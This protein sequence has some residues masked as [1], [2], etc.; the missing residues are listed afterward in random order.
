MH[1]LSCIR[2]SGADYS[3]R[4][5][6]LA[7]HIILNDREASSF[8]AAGNTPAGVM[9]GEQWPAHDGYCG[10][11]EEEFFLAP[12]DPE[13]TWKFWRYYAA[14]PECR[15][16]LC[17][18]T[19]LRGAVFVY[20]KGLE[21]QTKEE[22][23]GVLCLFAESQ[24][25][26]ANHGWGITFTTSVEPNDE[27]SE[28][29]WIGVPEKSPLLA[30]L[31]NATDREWVTLDSPPVLRPL[32]QPTPAGVARSP[33]K[34]APAPRRPSDSP[35]VPTVGGLG[36]RGVTPPPIGAKSE[37]AKT[38]SFYERVENWQI[39]AVAVLLLAVVAVYVLASSLFAPPVV[40]FE[41]HLLKTIYSGRPYDVRPLTVHPNSD[42]AYAKKGTDDWSLD[43]PVNAERYA[44]RLETRGWFG[45]KL[46]P[47][48][49]VL[50]IEKQRPIIRFA[51]NLEFAQD[52]EG[53]K[54][55]PQI[56]PPEAAS[57]VQ[58]LFKIRGMTNWTNSP[59]RTVGV[60]EVQVST[61]ET[62]NYYPVTAQT[63]FKIT[64]PIVE[65]LALVEPADQQQGGGASS[66]ALAGAD[67]STEKNRFVL[68]PESMSNQLLSQINNLSAGKPAGMEF[69]EIG[70]Q[71]ASAPNP[72]LKKTISWNLTPSGVPSDKPA[73]YRGRPLNY[74]L[75]YDDGT[76][77]QIFE[78]IGGAG[79]AI[80][81][82]FNTGPFYLER[83]GAV[84]HQVRLAPQEF[85]SEA[86]EALPN[87]AHFEVSFNTKDFSIPVLAFR[88]GS[89]GWQTEIPLKELEEEEAA[90]R[91][92]V[93]LLAERPAGSPAEVYYQQA[94]KWVLR[95]VK[96]EDHEAAK[97][98]FELK[99][100]A[101]SL[102]EAPTEKE[103][104][105]EALTDV[106]KSIEPLV[107]L[108]DQE[109]AAKEK[110]KSDKPGTDA[111][112]GVKVHRLAATELSDRLASFDSA[113][114]MV[115]AAKEWVAGR[116]STIGSGDKDKELRKLVE[117][118]VS[119]LGGEAPQ[120]STKTP[121]AEELK[122]AKEKAKSLGF[123]T[124]FAMEL[125]KHREK[126][127]GAKGQ[128]AFVYT[129]N[130]QTERIVLDDS[131]NIQPALGTK[132]RP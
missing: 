25:E 69:R 129:D 2:D 77:V 29:R 80:Q 4:T 64:K 120:M 114:K 115:Q 12:A 37:E 41:S 44:L 27:F 132:S 63:Q 32:A 22:A 23:V 110:E 131:V 17:A 67:S 97:K 61:I 99:R 10:W 86:L 59:P 46:N 53:P 108:G 3:G 62:E 55:K 126:P 74:Q 18:P 24:L 11:V 40:Q 75:S 60:H 56:S 16:N 45:T 91:Q 130:G 107:P 19:A 38:K 30:K 48:T 15:Y 54:I 105:R 83:V 42:V 100:D 81:K 90:A 72:W 106:V 52:G 35:D 1:V 36:V 95:G 7:Q 123:R 34:E 103:I 124:A 49:N 94:I 111:L 87:D 128:L 26:C 118:L 104:M 28:F 96:Q 31:E 113:S 14:S 89:S 122:A 92:R 13:R 116:K 50:V 73:N 101:K 51:E 47:L 8:A 33:Q 98:L 39:G 5:N 125:G 78:L 65:P 121:A 57:G 6:H 112:E 68:L 58:M 66:T 70:T 9:L 85:F 79:S 119:G 109:R 21:N 43:P 20:S 127:S 71:A 88:R 93:Q 102:G 117:G 76:K 82:L 84:G